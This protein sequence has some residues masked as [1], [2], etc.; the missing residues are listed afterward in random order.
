MTAVPWL[1]TAGL[2]VLLGLVACGSQPVPRS[3]GAN[4]SPAPAAA[5]A[6]WPEETPEEAGTAA[7]RLAAGADPWRGDPVETALAFAREVLGWE[8]PV[9]GTVE[10]QAAGLTL[11]EVRRGPGGPAVSV[12]VAQ[13]VGDRWWSVYNVW[14]T[15]E[16]DPT[17]SVR[18]GL[19]ELGFDPEGAA[20]ATVVVEYGDLRLER[21]VRRE[22]LVRFDL[23]GSPR[24]PGYF[25]VL[26]RDG[27]GAV[28]DAV[29]SPLPAG[30]FAAG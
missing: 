19:F 24:V 18:D 16:H 12:R 3:V 6:I 4:G 11:V 30:D 14:G 23:G 5:F 25:L 21:E 1:R 9:V 17:V 2:C 15:P 27:G 26:L 10:E 22:G 7:E 29:S 13:L 8:E 20:S 28:F